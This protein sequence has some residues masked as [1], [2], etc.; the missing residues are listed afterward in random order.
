MSNDRRHWNIN[1]KLNHPIEVKLHEGNRP[2]LQPIYHSA[3]FTPSE[4]FPYWDQFIYTRVSNPTTR[5]LELTLAE[6]QNREDYIVIGSGIAALTGTFLALLKAGDH[7]ITFRELYKPARIY[8][9]EFLP[10]YNIEHTTLSLSHL[11]D[12]EGAIISG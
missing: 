2:L 8:I 3:K 9:R 10:L 11:E 7:I 5:H 1:T 4:N 12:L 6:L